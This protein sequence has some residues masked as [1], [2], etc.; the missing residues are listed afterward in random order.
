MKQ[1]KDTIASQARHKEL[2]AQLSANIG[3]GKTKENEVRLRT[4]PPLHGVF[5]RAIIQPTAPRV[6]GD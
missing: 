3:L 5:S 1:N 2:M 6:S 4:R